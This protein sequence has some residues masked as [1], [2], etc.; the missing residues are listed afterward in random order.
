M[1]GVE[2][3]EVDIVVE[4]V[5]AF[6]AVVENED[7]RGETSVLK[8]LSFGIGGVGMDVYEGYMSNVRCC[9]FLKSVPAI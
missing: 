5:E 6:R 8:G 4:V 7:D 2:A 3:V 1:T 9:S